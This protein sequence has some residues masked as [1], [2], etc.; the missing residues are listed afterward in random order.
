MNLFMPQQKIVSKTRTGAKV[1]KRYDTATTPADRLLRD[2]PDALCPQDRAAILT[3]LDT[4][5]PA[6]LRRAI[7]DLQNRLVYL[8][9]QRGPS[10]TGPNATT[11]T[12]AAAS[13]T[14]HPESGHLQISQRPNQSGHL[15]MS[16]RAPAEP[17][18]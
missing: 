14:S 3:A 2:H 7:G 15:D 8:A 11:S 6:G 10:P 1:A 12:T 9:K 5:N 18:T 4:I 17:P 13:S 16:R